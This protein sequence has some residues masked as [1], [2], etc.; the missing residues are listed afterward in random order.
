MEL[1]KMLRKTV[2]LLMVASA[3]GACA[4]TKVA[5]AGGEVGAVLPATAR[6][7]PVGTELEVRTDSKLSGKHNKIG[8]QFAVTVRD[9]VMAQN[10]QVAVPEGS[11]VYGHITAL[12]EAPHAGDPSLIR[13]SFDRIVV[14]GRS[15]S[16]DAAVTKVSSPAASNEK[17]G[18]A[19]V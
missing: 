16:I 9:N 7:L 17:I 13:V 3:L 15:H 6:A 1:D 4:R 12:K 2:A 19:H 11:Q 18:R 10:G 5:S 14:N 8:D